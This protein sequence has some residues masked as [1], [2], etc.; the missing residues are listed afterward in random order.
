[1]RREKG[2]FFSITPTVIPIGLRLHSHHALRNPT[3]ATINSGY[4]TPLCCT[5]PINGTSL[6]QPKQTS[7]CETKLPEDPGR[8][9]KNVTE[10]VL[11]FDWTQCHVA[12]WSRCGVCTEKKIKTLVR[13]LG[14]A[15]T[16]VHT[17]IFTHNY[18]LSS[19]SHGKGRHAFKHSDHKDEDT[20]NYLFQTSKSKPLPPEVN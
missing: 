18:S 10:F 7:N 11:W 16:H 2:F 12:L 9:A 6:L 19:L 3:T 1:M 17:L 14:N 20:F 15:Y 5:F 8:L 13:R 4:N